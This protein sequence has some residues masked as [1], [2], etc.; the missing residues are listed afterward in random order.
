MI[1]STQLA[2]GLI[3]SASA[4]TA[5]QFS[6]ETNPYTQVLGFV[7]GTFLYDVTDTLSIGPTV[8]YYAN[9]SSFLA[10]GVPMS[11]LWLSARGEYMPAGNQSSGF[12]LAG[13]LNQTDIELG[14]DCTD[15]FGYRSAAG[16]VG[17]K[18]I[19]R[20]GLVAKLGAGYSYSGVYDSVDACGSSI[21]SDFLMSGLV[22]EGTV[23]FKF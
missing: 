10:F 9:D 15:E 23:G 22:A 2:I 1:K 11:A 19:S 7:N 17:Y 12:Y 16:V 20:I 14:D 3:L 6:I 5:S 18:L 8:G 13:V 4:A 21:D